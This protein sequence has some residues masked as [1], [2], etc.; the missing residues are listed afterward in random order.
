MASSSST[1]SPSSAW[2]PCTT[3]ASSTR[4]TRK[5]LRS[6]YYKMRIDLIK[7][8]SATTWAR[9]R[10]TR[11][12]SASRCCTRTGSRWTFLVGIGVL[13]TP[14]PR[15]LTRESLPASSSTW[16][17]TLLSGF[18]L[19]G[20]AQK[21]DRI[22][23]TLAARYCALNSEVFPS[24]DVAFVLAFSVI[25]LQ[26][27]LHNPAIKEEKKMT[28][29][30]FRRNN[31]G[32]CNGR[33]PWTPNSSTK[34]STASRPRPSRSPRTTSWRR[35]NK[36]VRRWRRHDAAFGLNSDATRASAPRL[37]AKKGS[38]GP[39]VSPSDQARR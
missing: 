38:H 18:R 37:S 32:I 8:W 9:R 1:S 19:P 17:S 7:L 36:Q 5:L 34:F 4:P 25:M 30:G 39:V 35:R 13:C 26:T 6:S 11:T 29:D 28:K 20:E 21:I 16:P 14:S 12:G 3:R 2:L 33:R 31:R 10:R 23:E 22:M 27:D 24:A 15:E